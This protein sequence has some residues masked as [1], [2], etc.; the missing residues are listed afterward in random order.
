L[1]SNESCCTFVE[2]LRIMTIKEIQEE[3][4]DEFSMFDDWMK[5][6]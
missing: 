1:N 6:V 3:I 5:K 4:V 2:N